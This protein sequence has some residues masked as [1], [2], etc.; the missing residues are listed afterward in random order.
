K[1]R[2]FLLQWRSFRAVLEKLCLETAILQVEFIEF[3]GKTLIPCGIYSQRLLFAE[4]PV[5][6]KSR[7]RIVM[8]HKSNSKLFSNLF[9]K[10]NMKKEKNLK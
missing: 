2:H 3:E 8:H 9:S 10:E 1:S 4:K 6:N 5:F 7:L